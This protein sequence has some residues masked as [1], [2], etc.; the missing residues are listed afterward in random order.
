[1]ASCSEGDPASLGGAISSDHHLVHHPIEDGG[2]ELLLGPDVVVEGA[3][4]ETV[5]VAELSDAR[6]VVALSGEDPRRS[7]DDPVSRRVSHLRAAPGLVA[8]SGSRHR[9]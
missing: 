8:R 1:M 3:L 7:V 6:G 9:L 4:A 2:E 5:D